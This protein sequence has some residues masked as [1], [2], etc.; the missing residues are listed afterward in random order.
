[1]KTLFISDARV[2]A[3]ADASYRFEKGDIMAIHYD[4][5]D[6]YEV[7]TVAFYLNGLQDYREPTLVVQLVPYIQEGT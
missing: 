5:D 2:L 1:M 4:S 6:L 7:M 3:E